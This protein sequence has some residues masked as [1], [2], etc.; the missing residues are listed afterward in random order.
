M[1]DRLLQGSMFEMLAVTFVV[2]LT[3][4][5]SGRAAITVVRSGALLVS[6]MS[7]VSVTEMGPSGKARRAM[8]T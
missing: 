4:S 2:V 5:R 3:L 6:G 8:V 7:C 1:S